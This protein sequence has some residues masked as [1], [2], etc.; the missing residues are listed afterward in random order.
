M[1]RSFMLLL[2]LMPL[3]WGFDSRPLAQEPKT[4]SMVGPRYLAFDH[5]NVIHVYDR[6]GE[7]KPPGEKDEH[8]HIPEHFERGYHATL[9]R[10]AEYVAYAAA[11]K[12]RRRDIVV[13][14]RKSK[15]VLAL[16]GANSTEDEDHPSIS[17]DGNLIAFNTLDKTATKTAGI[18]LYDRKEGK[19]LDLPNLDLHTTTGIP[20]LSPDGRYI[21]FSARTAARAEGDR[22]VFLYEREAKK[23]TEPPGLNSPYDDWSARV[24]SGGRWIAFCSRRPGAGGADV[25]LYDREQR[26]FV[27]L[28]GLNTKADEADCDLS[29]DGRVLIYLSNRQGKPANKGGY[30]PLELLLYD[31]QAGKHMETPKLFHQTAIHFSPALS[32]D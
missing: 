4:G 24:S 25:H 10:N 28:P 14:E 16:P 17:A 15:K 1:S 19:L 23:L 29:A 32:R 26:Q 7:L 3:T 13:W 11:T 9:S 8:P 21:V 12:G 2:P 18:R 5:N 31:R 20:S 30:Q 27:D 6:L 22:D